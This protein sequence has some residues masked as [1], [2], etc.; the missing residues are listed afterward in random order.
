MITQYISYP[1]TAV[2]HTHIL[3]IPL[4]DA[5][6]TML[7]SGEWAVENSL[8]PEK[9]ALSKK[10]L[11]SENFMNSQSP[12][13]ELSGLEG[14]NDKSVHE[15]RRKSPKIIPIKSFDSALF[16]FNVSYLKIY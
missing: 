5:L 7:S 8:H 16:S 9:I 3:N 11:G 4:L 2:I 6:Q 14:K 1:N 13:S 12:R 15:Q 10:I